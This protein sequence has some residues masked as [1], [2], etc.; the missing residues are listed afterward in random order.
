[1]FQ[2]CTSNISCAWA[3]YISPFIGR[4]DDIGADGMNLISEIV[5]IYNI[6]NFKTEVLAASIE[7]FKML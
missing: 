3:T 5:E 1:M 2:R 6:Y 4:L 7:G